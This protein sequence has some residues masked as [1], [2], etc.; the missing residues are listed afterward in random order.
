MNAISKRDYDKV[1]FDFSER[2]YRLRHEHR[3]EDGKKKSFKEISDEIYEFTN[4]TVSISHTQ[5]AKYYKLS[6]DEDDALPLTPNIKSVLAIA[7]YYDVPIEYMLGL[8]DTKS[9][10]DKD[11]ILN[12]TY[13]LSEMSINIL[14]DMK[15]KNHI[16]NVATA[17]NNVFK[18]FSGADL[19]NFILDNLLYELQDYCNRYFYEV[20]RLKKLEEILDA[21]KIDFINIKES[22]DKKIEI[23]TEIKNTKDLVNYRK[24]KISQLVDSFVENLREELESRANEIEADNELNRDRT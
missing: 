7:D 8:S 15:E 4:H 2:F 18:K 14:E 22:I 21:E 20:Q 19:V 24:Y 12:D 5:L 13:G 9:Y 23:E 3:R 10:K 17:E 16:F 11:K 6:L 1:L